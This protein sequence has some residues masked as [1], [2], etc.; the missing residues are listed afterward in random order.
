[1]S[2]V[3]RWWKGFNW[4]WAHWGSGQ[5][6]LTHHTYQ[7]SRGWLSY[8][9]SIELVAGWTTS[10]FHSEFSFCRLSITSCSCE[11]RYQAL[12]TFPY[13]KRWKAGWGPG[14]R[15][16]FA[17]I[18]KFLRCMFVG[19]SLEN[20]AGSQYNCCKSVDINVSNIWLCYQTNTPKWWYNSVQARCTWPCSPFLQARSKCQAH[21]NFLVPL[22]HW[23]TKLA[24]LTGL[25]RLAVALHDDEK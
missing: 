2:R 21:C 1:M 6:Y 7:A 3:E 12:P 25:T 17:S 15:L 10:L 8:T 23:Y 24:E 4:T 14:A 18:L 11:K 22:T 16:G 19:S 20:W 9:P 13:C 5:Q